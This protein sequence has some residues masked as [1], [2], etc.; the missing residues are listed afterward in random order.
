[1]FQVLAFVVL[2]YIRK[3]TWGET[4]KSEGRDRTQGSGIIGFVDLKMAVDRV[5]TVWAY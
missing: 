5:G 4:K 2:F 3:N 1:M